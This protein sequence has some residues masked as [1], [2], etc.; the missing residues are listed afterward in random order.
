MDVELKARL[1]SGDVWMRALYMIFF[2]IAY[3]VAELLITLTVI[4]QFLAILFTGSANTPLLQFGRN[5]SEYVFQIIQFE[6]FNSETKPFPLSDWP[7]EEPSGEQWQGPEVDA[8]DDSDVTETEL[9]EEEKHQP[10]T[11]AETSSNDDPDPVSKSPKDAN[12]PPV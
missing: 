6:T 1:T 4:F 3:S 5:L 2:A 11:L 12:P 8:S 7:D 10:E 9:R